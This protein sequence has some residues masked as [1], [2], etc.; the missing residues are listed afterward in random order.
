MGATTGDGIVYIAEA[1]GAPGSAP[2]TGYTTF[3]KSGVPTFKG[4]NNTNEIGLDGTKTTT[5]T[6]GAR[7]LPANPADFLT[8]IIGG[9]SY[10]LP[11]YNP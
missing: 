10:K 3:A 8:V 4:A 1:T 5:A 2:S 9:T 7:T 11:L 6:G